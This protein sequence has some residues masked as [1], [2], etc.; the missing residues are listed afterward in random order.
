[1]A[2]K[3]Y[4]SKITN[5]TKLDDVMGK[6]VLVVD[7]TLNLDWKQNSACTADP[8]CYDL[9]AFCNLESGS[10]LMRIERYEDLAK[11][12][13]TP[14]H[15]MNDNINTDVELIRVVEP[16]LTT[17]AKSKFIKNPVFKDYIMNYGAQ[18]IK[19]NYNNKD[20]AL[21]DYEKFFNDIGFA[22][23]PISSAIQYFKQ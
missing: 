11:Q 8:N 13:T 10:E 21:N 23:V 1:L 20:Q 17:I 15:I 16:D 6:V 19:Y 12:V 9:S 3:L 7:R 2:A 14:P 5:K 18:I 22:F 4:P